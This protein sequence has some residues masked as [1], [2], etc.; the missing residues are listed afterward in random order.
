MQLN[1]RPKCSKPNTTSK[2]YDTAR[3][4][5]NGV[6]DGICLIWQLSQK[7]HFTRHSQRKGPTCSPTTCAKFMHSRWRAEKLSMLLTNGYRVRMFNPGATTER[8]A[9]KAVHLCALLQGTNATFQVYGLTMGLSAWASVRGEHPGSR[10]CNVKEGS[11]CRASWRS[12]WTA[13]KISTC[14]RASVY[15]RQT[16]TLQR[17]RM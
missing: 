7:W 17:G 10:I 5:Q 15:L 3:Q 8:E 13:S 12:Y 9:S 16:Q 14:C 2:F 1:T 11:L 4:R 6:Q